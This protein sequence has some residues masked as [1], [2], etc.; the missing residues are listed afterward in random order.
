M[1]DA[2]KGG[3]PAVLVMMASFNGEKYIAEQ[4]D[5]ILSQKGVD[6]TLHICDDGSSDSTPAICK[7]YAAKWDN[8]HFEVNKANKGLAKNFMDMVYDESAFGFDYYAFSDQD[9][10]WLPEKLIHAIREIDSKAH[11]VPA[12][13][14]SDIE[15]VGRD[16]DGGTREYASWSSCSHELVAALT[17]NWASGC[18]MV[19]NSGLRSW[20]LSYEPNS[21]DRIHDGW[22]H[23]VAMVSGVVISDLENSFIKRRISGENQVGQR[24]LEATESLNSVAKRWK[25]IIKK[26]AHCQTQVAGYLLDGYESVMGRDKADLVRM[27]A[28]MPTSFFSR[29]EIGKELLHCPFPS[30]SMARGFAIKALLNRL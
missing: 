6:L 23:L 15:N 4:I 18:T 2:R 9:D 21:Y 26:S 13:Y 5:S 28:K 30:R 8:V 12:L 27:Y 16:L 11:G 19:F 24:D 1:S 3:E 22:V 14:Y 7:S 10:V 29:I 17:V 25:H 20:I